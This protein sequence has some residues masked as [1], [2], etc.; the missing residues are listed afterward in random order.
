[1]FIYLLINKK[2]SKNEIKNLIEWFII[3][4]GSLRCMKLLDKLKSLGFDYVT[5]AGLSL[6]L[7]DLVV[8]PAIGD[9]V[10]SGDVLENKLKN[11]LFSARLSNFDYNSKLI[12]C[13]NQVSEN[14]K[15]DIINNFREK[16][17]LNPLYMMLLSGAR[18]NITQIKQLVGMRGLMVDSQGEIIN[19]PIKNNLKEGL[20]SLEYFISC[21][22]ARKGVIDTAIKTANSGYLTRKLIYAT[23][24]MFV[25]KPNC[26]TNNCQLVLV[27]KKNKKYYTR[28]SEQLLGRVLAKDLIGKSYSLSRGQDICN[29]LVKKVLNFKKIYIRSPFT[30]RLNEGICQLCYGWNLS[31]GRIVELGE[32][33]G[34][35]AAQS[36]SE[37]ATQL[38][39]RTFH[40]GGIF[41]GVS[42]NSIRAGY[43]GFLYY[44]IK[45]GGKILKVEGSEKVFLF[46]KSKKLVLV[47]NLRKRLVI[48]LPAYSIIY[49]RNGEKVFSNQIVAEISTWRRIKYSS[50]EQSV[51]KT[52]IMIDKDAPISGM[53]KSI[54]KSLFIIHGNVISFFL[55]IS[56]LVPKD[57]FRIKNFLMESILESTIKN[58]KNFSKQ[59]CLKS[60]TFRYLLSLNKVCS[61]L[62]SSPLYNHIV[63]R[64]FNDKVF[65]NKKG[66][67]KSLLLDRVFPSNSFILKNSNICNKVLSIYP[68][69]VIESQLYIANVVNINCTLV[70]NE[71]IDLNLSGSLVNKFHKLFSSVFSR[72]KVGDIVQGLPAIES[73]LENKF[74]LNSKLR[75]KEGLISVQQKLDFIYNSFSKFY[76]Q[77]VAVRKSV[78]KIQ[79]YLV[80]RIKRVYSDQNVKLADK[81]LEIV[82]RQMTS[83]GIVKKEG[84]SGFI[85]GELVALNKL[86]KTN[87]NI[88]SKVLYFPLIIGISKLSMLSDSLLVASSFQQTFFTFCGAAL[89]GKCDWL[90]TLKGNIIVGNLIPVLTAYKTKNNIEGV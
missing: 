52:K 78:Y 23:E 77:K 75:K 70:P 26:N 60:T 30:C 54:D 35:I 42:V 38:T 22:G 90:H 12:Q 19:V 76:S 44:D 3:M 6:G 20:R 39:M 8:P 48:C 51:M 5:Q 7:S 36:I 68:F 74:V 25:K 55:L 84:E 24:N 27:L 34:V 81:H 65:L 10:K 56:F 79:K 59:Q 86:E 46:L 57:L 58:Y 37:P 73:V 43:S 61:I 41:S 45:H 32:N 67:V 15:I 17:L 63:I 82:V 50:S 72:Q 18:G 66:G 87:S 28:T 47:T 11:K 83:R 1:M 88:F 49:V 62:N 14:I 85:K 71:L 9:I 16:N 21:Y 80:N 40:T 69:Q 89:E 2:F 4:F 29:Y 31:Y 33:I 64:L 53:I 13:W